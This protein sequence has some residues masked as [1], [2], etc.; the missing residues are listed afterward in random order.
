M[1]LTVGAK[2]LYHDKNRDVSPPFE[3][4]NGKELSWS[5]KEDWP[6]LILLL[7][8][9]VIMDIILLYFGILMA[10]RV[11]SNN[12]ELILHLFFAIF[13]D[14]PYVFFN[15]VFNTPAFKTLGY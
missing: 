9:I 11:A 2:Y 5:N 10:L 3:M 7:A 8:P 4:F 13:F 1:L 14:L 12:K 15:T 6:Y